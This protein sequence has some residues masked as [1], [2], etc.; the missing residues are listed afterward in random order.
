MAK[1]GRPKK[2]DH[3]ANEL[4][5]MSHAQFK[6]KYMTPQP[7]TEEE[8]WAQVP[9]PANAPDEG[10]HLKL[11]VKGGGLA[12]PSELGFIRTWGVKGWK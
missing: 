3:V 10:E 5:W 8:V 4:M 7:V 1:M 9:Q 12:Y 2:V 11:E 6:D